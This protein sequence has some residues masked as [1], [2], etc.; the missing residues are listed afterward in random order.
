MAGKRKRDEPKSHQDVHESRQFQVYGK[1]P[2]APKA[3]KKLRK[4]D[5]SALKKQVHASSVNPIKK[6][7]RDITR[8][9]KRVDGLPANVRVDDERALAGYQQELAAAKAEKIRQRMI[10]K[11]HMVRFFERQ[12]AT[13]RVNQIRKQI[14]VSESADEVHILKT[15]MHEAEVDLNYTQY[16]PLSEPYVSL[17]A[18]KKNANGEVEEPKEGDAV[19]KPPM[20]AEVDRC[21]EK[22]TLDRLRNRVPEIRL[23]KPKPSELRPT[24]SKPKPKPKPEVIESQDLSGLNR[25]ERRSQQRNKVI[26]KPKNRSAGFAKNEVFGASEIMQREITED[27]HES[28]GGFFEDD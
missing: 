19:V 4:F 14:L 27:G 12:K 8:R 15:Q 10:K 7:I 25:R 16:Y 17:Y 21:M 26:G 6:H 28:D 5:P 22:K 9:I 1:A 18:P 20:W 24:K 13:R 23:T 11:Y 3:S 2:K